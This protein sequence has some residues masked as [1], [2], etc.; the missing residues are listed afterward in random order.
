[1]KNNNFTNTITSIKSIMFYPS[2]LSK[3][4][5]KITANRALQIALD[6]A[7]YSKDE[8]KD[9]IITDKNDREFKIYN[10]RFLADD[11]NYDYEIDMT[12]G[13]ILNL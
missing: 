4:L 7:G 6:N 13:R 1:M 5:D 2:A 10:I 3:K 8:T 9:I 11:E 12:T